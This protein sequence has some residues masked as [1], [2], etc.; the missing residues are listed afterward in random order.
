MM[1]F[2]R[3]QTGECGGCY[4]RRAAL[5]VEV[6]ET[7]QHVPS[8]SS[9][10]MAAGKYRWLNT[11]TQTLDHESILINVSVCVSSITPKP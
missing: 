2:H 5:G 6:G 11:L 8:A 9:V 10:A 4:R 3:Q 7:M 1:C